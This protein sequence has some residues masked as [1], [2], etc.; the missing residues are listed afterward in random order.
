VYYL[1][2]FLYRILDK[3]M[4][5]STQLFIGNFN[6]RLLVNNMLSL[7]SFFPWQCGVDA[8]A[9]NRMLLQSLK[10]SLHTNADCNALVA[11]VVHR[12]VNVV[13]LLLQ[14]NFSLD[15]FKPLITTTVWFS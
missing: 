9:T 6:L 2:V 13:S 12:Q 14:V 10:P 5:S 7:S 3:L 15:P 1:A 8:S 11:A 4:P